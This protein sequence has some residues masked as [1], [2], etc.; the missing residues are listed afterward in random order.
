MG[1]RSNKKIIRYRRIE[2]PIKKLSYSYAL[3]YFRICILSFIP[4]AISSTITAAMR[5]AGNTVIPCIYNT[6]ANVVNIFLN[7]VL[8]NG[9]IG[10]P[11]L[12]IA[13][14]AIA[15]VISTVIGLVISL[16]VLAS[17]KY[18]FHFHIKELFEKVDAVYLR[19]IIR[20]GLPAMA[21]HLIIRVGLL[22]FTK[23]VAS[24]GTE[25][26]ATHTICLNI[27]TL[28][29]M[30]GMAFSVASTTKSGQSLG[31][32]REDLAVVYSQYCARM[33]CLFSLFLSIIYFFFGK[34]LISLYN[35][36]Q[37]I[38]EKGIIPLQ[39]IAIMQPFSALQYV[40]SGAIRGAGDTKYT[41]M[42]TTT[43]TFFIRPFVAYLLVIV[44]HLGLVGAWIGMVADQL[45]C[46]ILMCLRFC[47]G[48]WRYAYKEKL[49]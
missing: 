8:I 11:A 32:S 14:A 10:F 25:L 13:G 48:K 3:I 15:T 29:F 46:S 7:W 18:G 30:N 16:F 33:C 6:I 38:I 21:E 34:E 42:V 5:G 28:S 2:K 1:L 36:E 47:S 45:T 31:A 4:S 27:Q 19:E 23:I 9:K 39:L 17:Y 49:N 41:A 26:Y 24:L 40:F 35:H 44:F 37:T 20:I 12:G 43:T 22:V